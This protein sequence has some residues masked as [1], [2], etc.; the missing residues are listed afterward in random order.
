MYR[1]VDVGDLVE[2]GWHDAVARATWTLVEWPE[3][4]AAALPADRLDIAIGIDSPTARS[5]TFTARGPRHATVID[6]LRRGV[7]PTSAVR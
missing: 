4:I 5:L 2:L 6:F 7:A 3:R 1:L